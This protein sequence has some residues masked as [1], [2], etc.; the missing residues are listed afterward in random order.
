MITTEDIQDYLSNIHKLQIEMMDEVKRICDKYNI[1]YFLTFGTLLGAVRHKGFIPWDDDVDFGM[2][3]AEYNRFMDVAEKELDPK[4]RI[5]TIFSMEDNCLLFAKLKYKGTKMVDYY[6]S[7]LK[8][9]HE[10]WIDIF[11]FENATTDLKERKKQEKRIVLLQRVLFGKCHYKHDRKILYYCR[12]LFGAVYPGSKLR[13]K[14]LLVKES[15]KFENESSNIV[16]SA[17]S[18]FVYYDKNKIQDTID[19]QF[20]GKN[21]KGLRDYDSILTLWYGDYMKL[22][23]EDKRYNYQHKIL[24]VSFGNNC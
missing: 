18:P 14:Q 6:N 10:I 16:R 9:N 21:Y 17:G 24:D 11:P 15:R 8:Q 7:G 5:E 2:L 3:R 19:Y 12:N 4:F 22:P 23:P 13:I 20:E 1:N